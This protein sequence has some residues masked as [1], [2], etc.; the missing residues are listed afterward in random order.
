[1]QSDE[2]EQDA[3]KLGYKIWLETTGKAFGKGPCD[4]LTKVERLGSLKAATVEMGM[5]YS[6]AWKLIKGLERRLGFEL[7]YRQVGGV[8]GGGASLTPQAKEL[9]RS[10][11]ALMRE[12][13]GILDELFQ[14]H[15]SNFF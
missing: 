14:K 8:S 7:L 4:L 1:V 5:S 15:F 12:A 9:M 2:Q 11:K 6:H 13:E 3:L 10:Y